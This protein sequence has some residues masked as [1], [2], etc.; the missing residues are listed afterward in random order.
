[1]ASVGA[2]SN[3]FS[4]LPRLSSK[5]DPTQFCANPMCLGLAWHEWLEDQTT[6]CQLTPATNSDQPPYAFNWDTDFDE[7]TPA[8]NSDQPPYAF[9]WD[10]DFDDPSLLV[11]VCGEPQQQLEEPQQA[12]LELVQLQPQPQRQLTKPQECCFGVPKTEEISLARKQSVPKRTRQDTDYCV[13]LWNAWSKYRCDTTE[14]HIPSLIEM[15][16]HSLQ[17][18]MTHF[19]LEVR[20]KNGE[21]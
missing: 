14:I 10:T 4:E 1:M 19:V 20:K 12:A 15:D 17:Y 9:N 16:S 21:S 2:S 3:S 13:R 7:L 11:P 5:R 8:T 18:W 6:G